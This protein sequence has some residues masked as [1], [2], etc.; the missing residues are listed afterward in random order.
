M[1]VATT[2]LP[3]AFAIATVFTPPVLADTP[4]PLPPAYQHAVVDA[5]FP[6][7]S[8]IAHDLVPVTPDNKGLVWSADGTRIRVVSWKAKG[9]YEQFLKPYDHTSENPD[10]VVW[11][12]TTPQVRHFCRTYLKDH[13]KADAAALDLR[14][15]QYLGLAPDWSYDVFVEMWVKPEDMF[16]PCVDPQID[17]QTCDLHFGKDTPTVAGLENYRQFYSDLYYKSFRSGTGV[18]WTG[19]GYTYD[20]GNPKSDGGASEFILVPGAAYEIIDA[21]P[22]ETYCRR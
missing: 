13:P 2:L 18:P 12:T 4:P 15:K 10:Y 14:L 1:N 7:E 16:R 21:V 8:E 17:D 5:A 22:T 3:L 11:V 9:A 6:D 19:L 20:W